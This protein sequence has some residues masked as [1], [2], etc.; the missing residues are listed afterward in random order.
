MRGDAEEGVE[1]VEHGLNAKQYQA[2][3]SHMLENVN[4]A[5]PKQVEK[6]TGKRA[7]PPS[8]EQLAFKKAKTIF[9]EALRKAKQLSDEATQQQSEL[10]DLVVSVDSNG[11]PK[12]LGIHFK[13]RISGLATVS[14]AL[15]NL[16]VNMTSKPADD[17]RIRQ[18]VERDITEIEEHTKKLEC[19]Q[20][21]F[22][23]TEVD[24]RR[25]AA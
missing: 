3:T 18:D 10:M 23:R 16:Y 17:A 22:T 25:M 15:H 13:F 7:A 1:L 12:E 20:K 5:C 21:E 4:V 11:Y 24:I 14:T 9:S 2:A 8:E 6:T 19:A